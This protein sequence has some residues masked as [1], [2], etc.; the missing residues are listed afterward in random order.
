MKSNKS[1]DKFIETEYPCKE[2]YDL[3]LD[4]KKDDFENRKEFDD[5]FSYSNLLELDLDSLDK[6]Q[7]TEEPIRL[8]FQPHDLSSHIPLSQSLN[9]FGKIL[10]NRTVPLNTFPKRSLKKN[11]PVYK[12]ALDV[13]L[14]KKKRA[15]QY[16][17]SNHQD[18][19]LESFSPNIV[20][21]KGW[22]TRKIEAE[23]RFSGFS[24]PHSTWKLFMVVLFG[25]KL[26]FYTPSQGAHV[27]NS[28]KSPLSRNL[29]SNPSLMEHTFSSSE[30]DLNVKSIL[31]DT[32]NQQ[33]FFFGLILTEFENYIQKLE[34]YL[35]S[36]FFSK[37]FLIL[38]Y[39]EVFIPNKDQ[40]LSSNSNIYTVN[41]KRLWKLDV[42]YNIYDINI[43]F[44]LL[45]D[46]DSDSYEFY[47]ENMCLMVISNEKL[48]RR[49]VLSREQALYFLQ[50]YTLLQE[51]LKKNMESSTLNIISSKLT[52][53]LPSII[54]DT[55]DI[56]F[57]H[58][59]T[60]KAATIKE[61]L[62]VI[63][64]VN[65]VKTN[66]D[67]L[68]LFSAIIGFWDSPE[69]ILKTSLSIISEFPADFSSNIE[70][71][72]NIWCDNCYSLFQDGVFVSNIEELIKRGIEPKNFFLSET[73][74]T[75]IRN[76]VFIIKKNLF[77]LITID[78]SLYMIYSDNSWIEL[79]ANFVLEIPPEIFSSELYYF[80]KRFLD[81]WDPSSDLSLF[82]NKT[83]FNLVKNPLVFG[84][85][86][87][88]FITKLILD[89]LLKTNNKISPEFRA[90]IC[91]YWISVSH[92]LKKYGDMAGW[93][94]I[95]IALCSPPIIRLKKVWSLVD[96]NLRGF[97]EKCASIMNDLLIFNLRMDDKITTISHSL[98]LN[99]QCNIEISN[100]SIPYYGEILNYIE[101]LKS[102][103]NSYNKII[104]VQLSNDIFILV[105]DFL[106]KWRN[107]ISINKTSYVCTNNKDRNIQL[108]ELFKQLNCIR[109]NPQSIF[110][111]IFFKKSLKCEPL[112]HDLYYQHDYSRNTDIKANAYT[113]LIFNY[114]YNSYNLFDFNDLFNIYK[115]KSTN[116]N[117]K[118]H[119]I[120][121]ESIFFNSFNLS[122]S[123]DI[124]KYWRR[125]S[126]PLNKYS[127]FTTQYSG[128]CNISQSKTLNSRNR[129]YT[130]FRGIQDVFKTNQT[131]FYY[132]DGQLIL[133]L[134]ENTL[135]NIKIGNSAD[136]S[137]KNDNNMP[138]AFKDKKTD[139]IIESTQ[140]ISCKVVVKAGSLERLVDILVLG[141]DDFSERLIYESKN[142]QFDLYMNIE[143]YRLT[144][145]STFRSFCAPSTLLE[146][147][148]KRLAGSKAVASQ[149]GIDM[150]IPEYVKNNEMFPDWNLLD[151]GDNECIIL[152]FTHYFID[153]INDLNLL[154]EFYSFFKLANNQLQNWKKIVL[155]RN[156]LQS[157]M[158]QYL[159]LFENVTNLF[160]KLSYRPQIKLLH[161]APLKI[162]QEI[163]ISKEYD[164]NG[165]FNL[166]CTLDKLVVNIF[167]T[168]TLGDWI[169]CFELLEVQCTDINSFFE[170]QKSISLE[171]DH[172]ILQDIY[173]LLSQ[174][175]RTR[176]HDLLINAFPHPIKE[177]FRLRH[178]I[179]DW[180]LSQITDINIDCYTRANRIFLYLR[181]LG[182]YQLTMTRLDFFFDPFDRVNWTKNNFM[183]PSFVGNAI[184]TALLRPESRLF[185]YAWSIIASKR[186]LDGQVED[187]ASIV[188]FSTN[189]TTY[190]FTPCIGW[191]FEYLLKI[192]LYIPNVVGSS[193]L[194]NFVKQIF[195]YDFVSHI[196]N[197]NNR[198][199]SETDQKDEPSTSLND[200][201]INI[202]VH[203]LSILEMI[204][205]NENCSLQFSNIEK[206]FQNLIKRKILT[207][208]RNQKDYEDI[209]KYFQKF[210][211]NQQKNID[212]KKADK[213]IYKKVLTKT[214][215]KEN[216]FLRGSR[217]N[218]S[219]F[220]NNS[221]LNKA[222]D[223]STILSPG[224]SSSFS[225]SKPEPLDVIDL[226]NS[227]VSALEISKCQ[228][229]FKIKSK[230]GIKTLLRAPSLNEYKIWYQKIKDLAIIT[231]T[232]KKNV[233][234][235][236]MPAE[237]INS[238]MS[239]KSIT[240]VN[241]TACYGVE[242]SL[243]CA[244]DKSNIPKIVND[245]INEVERRGLEDVG[246][247]RVPGSVASI[248][249]LKALIDSGKSVNMKDC[250]WT[251]INI[252][253]GALKLWLRELPEPLMTYKLYP[254][255]IDLTYISNYHKKI[256]LL[257]MLIQSLP[258]YNYFLIKRFIEHFEKIISY[259]SLNQMHAHNL[260][261]IFGPNFLRPCPL[262]YS[263]SQ[264]ISHI[265][266][267]QEIVKELIIQRSWIFNDEFTPKPIPN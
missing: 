250:R 111:D 231:T 64:G 34:K 74:R 93:L 192:V 239:R 118:N 110:S 56:F 135:E 94:S 143:E 234:T 177:L 101:I 62:K 107:I 57:N 196:I 240:N 8:S 38:C 52:P 35:N 219:V 139:N 47:D 50:K 105:K 244:R 233:L 259:E 117:T 158:T 10:D 150:K 85:Y 178:N 174:I 137:F 249:A 17:E 12:S 260:A 121:E 126:F 133:K 48:I 31:Y 73:L 163:D 39:R 213:K 175:R 144:F 200:S 243:L 182:V 114:I 204:S 18:Q 223:L 226:I 128:F 58:D 264:V 11:I 141:L 72:V 116:H 262:D 261:I 207:I 148:K 76:I 124:Y 253:A 257:K 9:D 43:A 83:S 77:D 81:T 27:M 127:A 156:E 6:L 152:W 115:D 113:S 46:H 168:L 254:Q 248:N 206:P 119:T 228:Y 42:V 5:L 80:H 222:S 265:E 88:H 15:T 187:L 198:N 125:N 266:K 84:P 267:T 96:L 59:Q 149:I 67:L 205:E 235:K 155:M 202:Q 183:I 91:T 258:F 108:Q 188:P 210:T 20:K 232:K 37:N 21:H 53:E 237:L 66:L 122:S 29:I 216:I 251:D 208:Q 184:A 162:L 63:L 220:V 90:E 41:L 225:K 236:S 78:M 170:C 132:T 142:T 138:E 140:I 245:L 7:E 36:I 252:I 159:N 32:N 179:I 130:M 98:L 153:F 23:R 49:F 19:H 145:L 102:S 212:I 44:N 25:S 197:L 246:I 99:N 221:S 33:I 186:G 24:K 214:K 136:I 14:S 218:S 134:V 106:E 203:D 3:D 238:P 157:H 151:T 247:Y 112:Y 161:L 263:F 211:K 173:S 169:Y 89:Q 189:S 13:F 1:E 201:V 2:I 217:S 70:K 230:N 103:F 172:Y 195:V 176:T 191:V 40:N 215:H 82:F 129:A 185:I 65:N 51:S 165:I 209:K 16:V 164:D 54:N 22:L 26:Y 86:N 160:L 61:L 87:M 79:P 55:Q 171:N 71:M 181:L 131:L 242:L 229:I 256:V 120:T 60:L 69:I 95:I 97:I 123:K 45:K 199:N 224:F 4:L 30:F 255:F 166:A 180:V 193:R 167:N 241:S 190:L 146:Y 28:G 227:S 92:Y 154:N 75:K 100:L 147:F 68:G 109:S 104:D 194:I